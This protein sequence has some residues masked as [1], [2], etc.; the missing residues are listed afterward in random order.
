MERRNTSGY[1]NSLFHIRFDKPFGQLLD[2][3]KILK[4]DDHVCKTGACRVYTRIGMIYIIPPVAGC[5]MLLIIIAKIR[6]RLYR[7]TQKNF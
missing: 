4:R 1:F 3:P 7:I 6:C 2:E 5:S